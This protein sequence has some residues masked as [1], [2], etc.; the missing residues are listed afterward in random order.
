MSAQK[1]VPPYN[2][3]IVYLGL[4]E[5][6]QALDWLERAFDDRDVH[7]VFLHVEPKWDRLR[8]NPRFQNRSR[9]LGLA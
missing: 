2:L 5:T 9:R 6:R 1:Y 7:L 8:G 3:A 4:G